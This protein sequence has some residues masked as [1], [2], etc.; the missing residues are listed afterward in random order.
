MKTADIRRDYN[1]DSLERTDLAEEP[2]QQFARWL[3]VALATPEIPDPTA[4]V[5]ATA[6]PDGS[7]LQR[8]VLLKDYSEQGFT[9]FTDLDSQ[10]GR[11]IAANPNVSALFQWLPLSRQII[12]TGIAARTT[13]QEDEQYFASRPRASQI[14]ACAS[15]QSQTLTSREQLEQAYTEL[16]ARYAD[17][18][19]PC[20]EHWGGF[21]I[22]PVRF[23]FWQGRPSRLHDR[24]AYYKCRNLWEINRL[25]P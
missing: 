20:P 16:E 8:T 19:I 13:R 10:K 6:Q 12:I 17:Q 9:F 7:L 1:F 21:R 3:S 11:A 5:L 23:E 15:L 2:L 18:P 25:S 22:E 4:M 14:A 24:F